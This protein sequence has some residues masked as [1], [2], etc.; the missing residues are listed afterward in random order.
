MRECIKKKIAA[1][2]IDAARGQE[3]LGLLDETEEFLKSSRGS[4]D[5]ADEAVLKRLADKVVNDKRRAAL[6]AKAMTNVLAAGRSNDKGFLKGVE[7]MIYADGTGKVN[8]E[9]KRDALIAQANAQMGEG[10]KKFEP[11]LFGGKGKD[12]DANAENLVK[13]IFGIRTGDAAMSALAKSW[14]EVSEYLRVR[15]NKAGGDIP[16]LDGWGL[17]QKHDA[18][19]IREAGADAWRDF[20]RDRLDWEKMVDFETGLPMTPVKREAFLA[21]VYETITTNGLNKLNPETVK[22]GRGMLANAHREHRVLAFKDADAWMEYCRE[23]GGNNPVNA[24]IDHI[25]RMAADISEIELFGPN[26]EQMREIILNY[27]RRE[28]VYASK[29]AG[30]GVERFKNLWDEM[31]GAVNGGEDGFIARLGSFT[32]GWLAASQLGGAFL[33]SMTDPATAA[34]VAAFNGMG[35]HKYLG[36]FAKM[37]FSS[38]D[39]SAAVRLGLI[40]DGMSRVMQQSYRYT[41]ERF[42]ATLGQRLNRAVMRASFLDAW[43]KAN[44]FAF[45]MELSAALAKEAGKDPSR[46]KGGIG[47][48]LRRYGLTNDEWARI[49]Q[50]GV[51]DVDGQR[52]LSL[53]EVYRNDVRLGEKLQNMFLSERDA[54]VIGSNLRTAAVMHQGTKAGTW[55][56]QVMRTIFMYK[57]FPLTFMMT[58]F[59]RAMMQETV[60][61]RVG[62]ALSMFM[63]MTAFGYVAM[64]AK[65]MARGKE[66]LP[67]SSRSLLRAAAQGGG[68]G[69][70]GDF[71]FSDANRFGNGFG[72]TLGGPV[73][74]F[75]DDIVR[76]TLGNVQEAA[77]GEKTDFL[78]EVVELL[79]RYVPGSSIW[80]SRLAFERIFLNQMQKITDPDAEQYFRRL[81]RRA[82]KEYGQEYWWRP[83]RLLPE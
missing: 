72:T 46:I 60:G 7:G 45:Q 26:P 61:G 37:I 35:V 17:P 24:M 32:R 33:S 69:I 29:E 22:S 23:F 76:L 57:S 5:G 43:T 80:Y 6:K 12:F 62:Y 42:D 3:V 40:A 25:Q 47:A 74:G 8:F 53:A 48:M 2:V 1:G 9:A 15:F 54:A 51:T 39:R 82:R 31:T 4:A 28:N 21:D 50:I 83:G 67:L 73:L 77:K 78:P 63:T 58:H 70:L 79:G 19:R 56:G 36:R 18:R 16:K 13:E 65:D 52:F 44:Q 81:E 59:R 55:Q 27:A 64:S 34:V 20:V 49:G 66:P 10:L 30:I 41:G 75:A 68:A 11:T 71:L 38:N 14:G